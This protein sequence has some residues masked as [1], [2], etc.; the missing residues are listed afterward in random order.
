M[1][2]EVVLVER[3]GQ[4]LEITL[5]RPE[6][7]NAITRD[8][9]ERIAAALEELDANSELRV[10]ILT[11]AGGYFSSGMDLRALTDG[12]SAWLPE[13]GFAGIVKRA[14]TKPLIAAVEGFAVA[15]GFEILLACDLVVASRAAYFSIPEVKRCLVPI[16]G[17]I[18]RLAE[19]LPENVARELVLTGESMDAERAAAFGLVNRLTEPGAA[20][21]AARE[22]AEKIAANAPLAVVAS[23]KIFDERAAWPADELWERQDAISRPVVASSDSR[24]G[25]LAFLEKREPRWQG[26]E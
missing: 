26:A 4:V 2:S 12:E 24:E 5:N 20:L 11:G 8:V 21:D 18:V 3:R 19:R 15:G 9:S 6:R 22:L 16:G 14:A 25:S 1:T 10:G 17:G 23:K 7:R 13:R